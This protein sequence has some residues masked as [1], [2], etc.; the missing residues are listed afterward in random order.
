MW[1]LVRLDSTRHHTLC[2]FWSDLT[3]W[4]TTLC[5]DSGQTWLH[6]P[7][8]SVWILVAVDQTLLGG[9]AIVSTARGPI[10]STSHFL[11]YLS[12]SIKCQL[13]VK[14]TVS[15]SS[16]FSYSSFSSRHNWRFFVSS[17][18][19]KW[20]R[21]QTWLKRFV[22]CPLLAFTV[23]LLPATLHQC[24]TAPKNFQGKLGV[25]WRPPT[26]LGQAELR[27]WVGLALGLASLLRSAD[28][29][30]RPTGRPY[31]ALTHTQTHTHTQFSPADSRCCADLFFW[32]YAGYQKRLEFHGCH[33]IHQCKEYPWRQ[34]VT[35]TSP[36]TA[37]LSNVPQVNTVRS[38][39]RSIANKRIYLH[40]HVHWRRLHLRGYVMQGMRR[41]PL[42]TDKKV[43]R[44]LMIWCNKEKSEMIREKLWGTLVCLCTARHAFF[45]RG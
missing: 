26:K 4:T 41:A 39:I 28:L 14:T 27:P 2:G 17:C 33:C 21:I 40:W 23:V 10:R 43:M 25:P 44:T 24:R 5:V 22:S 35:E 37:G 7:P 16:V 12:L 31:R 30:V 18:D 42:E 13:S 20:H 15:L 19:L 38:A 6:A 32:N 36:S 29:R 1:I 3:L 34:M 9:K 45:R 8:H 11:V